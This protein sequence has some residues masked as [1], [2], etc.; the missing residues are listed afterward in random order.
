MVQLARGALYD[1]TRSFS[2][3]QKRR[4]HMGQQMGR[5]APARRI[6][7]AA[8]PVCREDDEIH[9]LPPDQSHEP[10]SSVATTGD[11]DAGRDACLRHTPANLIEVAARDA[12]VAS[13]HALLEFEILSGQWTDFG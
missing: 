9:T 7:W 8:P 2:K 5:H 1:S 4:S 11:H 10:R 13:D 12:L 6:P 3:D